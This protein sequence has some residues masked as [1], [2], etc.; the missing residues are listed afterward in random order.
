V[1]YPQVVHL[2]NYLFLNEGNL[3]N[4]PLTVS[5]VTQRNFKKYSFIIQELQRLREDREGCSEHRF[6][7][8][9]VNE[10]PLLTDEEVKKYGDWKDQLER[11]KENPF[12][13]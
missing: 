2:E 6:S 9:S 13:K 5:R 10:N 12:N 1:D 8:L 7:E 3:S 11:L 4:E